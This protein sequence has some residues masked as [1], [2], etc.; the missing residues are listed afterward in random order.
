MVKKYSYRLPGCDADVEGLADSS[1]ADSSLTDGLADSKRTNDEA[2]QALNACKDEITRHCVPLR[3][4]DDMKRMSNE[5]ELV[6]TAPPPGAQQQH[7][8]IASVQPVSRSFF[9]LWELLNDFS[10]TLS[11]SCLSASG[12]VT[13]AFLAEGPGGFVESFAT[14]RGRRGVRCVDALHCITLRSS[15][16]AV[17]TW[18][19]QAIRRAAPAASLNVHHGADGTGDLYRVANIDHLVRAVCG[20]TEDPG[21]CE[22]VTADGGFDYSGDFNAQERASARLLLCEAYAALRLQRVG[23]AF[24][25]KMFDIASD[26]TMS[27]L[28]ALRLC[29]ADV[30]LYKP[31][32]SRPAN[33]E[34]YAVCTG[35][36]GAPPSLLAI[37]RAAVRT[38][39][40]DALPAAP[41]PLV[42]SIVHYN[43]CFVARQI[44]HIVGTIALIGA[45]AEARAKR[46]RAQMGKS[47]R[48]CHKYGIPISFRALT[49]YRSSIL[50]LGLGQSLNPGFGLGLGNSID[51]SSSCSSSDLCTSNA[52]LRHVLQNACGSGL[53]MQYERRS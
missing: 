22:L 25:L 24:V 41:S 9:K 35:F 39:R 40:T 20:P 12:P 38:A 47:I 13:A 31:L 6:Y 52:V 3:Q 16:R 5:Y 36:L 27:L 51:S 21:V 23:G 2:H 10:E 45:P 19:L 30:H 32:S 49:R 29:Y 44:A 15:S 28:H 34:K 14:F 1:L 50:G 18:K 37:L 7:Q 8:G 4:W 46:L 26:D 11:A 43:V 48:W 33:S 17:P 53:N 42:R